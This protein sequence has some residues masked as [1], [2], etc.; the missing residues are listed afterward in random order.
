MHPLGDEM[1]ISPDLIPSILHCLLQT[2]HKPLIF[3]R[4]NIYLN[5]TQENPSLSSSRKFIKDL[6]LEQ[7]HKASFR[8]REQI[9]QSKQCGCFFCCRIFP[10]SEVTDYV[11]REE[12][13]ALCPYCF[14]DS[15]FGD[16]SGYPITEDFLKEMN[17]RWY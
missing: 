11:S 7:A 2:V 10:A 15:V 12:P 4:G 3:P 5:T 17:K 8:N 14:T 13:T 16:A 6:Q 1:I 9:E